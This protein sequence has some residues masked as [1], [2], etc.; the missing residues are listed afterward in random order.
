MENLLDIMF[1][2]CGGASSGKAATLLTAIVGG[3]LACA[4]QEGA[5]D[6]VT[7][8]ALQMIS[9]LGLLP[10]AKATVQSHIA[11]ALQDLECNSLLERLRPLGEAQ[12]SWRGSVVSS[13][14]S[15]R[16]SPTALAVW[17]TRRSV[18]MRASLSRRCTL[19]AIFSTVTWKMHP[20][21][22]SASSLSAGRCSQLRA[23]RSR[24]APR[25]HLSQLGPSAVA[26]RGCSAPVARWR[27]SS[28]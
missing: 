21:A 5:V 1:I 8:A 9:D 15:L 16:G 14:S 4:G 19:N 13:H 25:V 28:A 20:R 6:K 7:Q 23:A 27:M 18:R 2:E 24:A 22:S 3:A 12:A 10:A 17:T 11:I 26:S